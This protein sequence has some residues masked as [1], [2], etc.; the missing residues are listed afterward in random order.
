MLNKF[1]S[2]MSSILKCIREKCHL[3]VVSNAMT[4]AAPSIP[5]PP[6]LIED[7]RLE[8]RSECFSVWL[9]ASAAAAAA[10][11]SSILRL[12]KEDNSH[13]PVPLC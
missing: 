7:D 11:S 1:F 5:E 13:D 3:F 6:D 4:D 10:A 9:A 12:Q 8:L 2:L